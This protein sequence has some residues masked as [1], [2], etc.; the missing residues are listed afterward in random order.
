MPVRA[1]LKVSVPA[2]P[3]RPVNR[4]RG[5][6]RQSGDSRVITVNLAIGAS[7]KRPRDMCHAGRNDP[8]RQSVRFP[9]IENSQGENI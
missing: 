5:H 2:N 8:T 3:N 1:A 9:I 4:P 6:P 7:A